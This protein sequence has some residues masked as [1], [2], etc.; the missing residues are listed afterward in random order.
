MIVNN[1]MLKLKNNDEKT[2]SKVKEE[3]MSMNGSVD[4]LK[5]IKVETNVLKKEANF[6]IFFQTKFDSMKDFEAYLT[7]PKHLKVS[8]SI[9][10]NIESSASVCSNSD[11]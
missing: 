3:L 1:V 6:D 2:L 10:S 5:D 11:E 4:V 8:E 7:H 9:G